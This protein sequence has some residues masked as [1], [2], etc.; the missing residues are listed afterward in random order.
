MSATTPALAAAIERATL[1]E[2]ERPGGRDAIVVG[3]GAAGG[4]AAALLT[5]AGLRVLVLDAGWRV[6]FHRAPLRRTIAS[7]L[8]MLAHP[9]TIALTPPSLRWKGE[10]LLRLMGR[11]RQP[12]QS[13]CYA[14][15]SAAELFV[16]DRECP[17]ET[18]PDQ[19]YHW[20]RARGLGGRMVVPLHGRQ[21]YR[22]GPS[23]FRPADGLSPP[24]PLEPGELDPWY[25]LVERRLALSGRTEHSEWVP[26]S[27]L[28]N[29]REPTPAEAA[30]VE[31]VRARYP[32]A[33]TLLGRFAPPMA[34]LA[35][36]AASGRLLCRTGAIARHIELDAQGRAAGVVFHD[37]RT[38]SLRVSRA[39]LIFLCASTLES[40]RILLASRSDRHPEGIGAA[41]DSLGRHLMDHVTIK[42]EG[43]APAIADTHTTRE[44]GPC[45]YLPRFND[46]ARADQG[47]QRGFGIRV[48][49]S[50]G[51]GSTS[52]FTAVAD[53]EMLPRPEN[54]VMLSSRT[55]A[56]GLPT[57]HIACAHGAAEMDV[58][59]RQAEALRELA[60]IAGAKLHGDLD[61]LPI[62]GSSIHEVGTA[63]M[64]SDPS[65]SVL[66]PFNECW[67]TKGLFVTDGA[68][69]PSLGIQNPT[70]T[71]LALT[72][73]ACHHAV[74]R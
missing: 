41:S 72:A 64:G 62:P 59:R 39:P 6:P 63:R 47:T 65:R 54:R 68:A 33:E 46:R 22:L 53:A 3:G 2:L 45:V 51:P 5:Q 67:E 32:K 40:T 37:R 31:K 43:V 48:Y 12:V 30:F 10:R 69:F 28:A 1:E 70:L 52:Y 50:P 49:Q 8:A 9:R 74:N 13:E 26:D 57:L 29:V 7:A 17:Y 19:P 44:M 21:Y 58:A 61:A 11:V 25:E 73:R 38:G 4:L 20:I 56:W 35:E 16:D 14:W 55:D 34:S 27:V 42:A 71:I 15:P 60:E 24:W 23:D 18:P 66:D 36:A